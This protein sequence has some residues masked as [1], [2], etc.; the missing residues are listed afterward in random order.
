MFDELEV[1][2]RRWP[3]HVELHELNKLQTCMY[4]PTCTHSSHV[5]LEGM[6]GLAFCCSLPHFGFVGC[7]SFVAWSCI[8]SLN[9]NF[10]WS[11]C[12]IW[13][14]VWSPEPWH[15][16]W[17]RSARLQNRIQTPPIQT[18][19]ICKDSQPHSLNKSYSITNWPGHHQSA[20]PPRLQRRIR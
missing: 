20:P 11:M 1:C 14:Y 8:V 6:A 7:I 18:R 16:P 13:V 10:T 12:K 3:C 9:H 2:T 4:I 19:C 17:R 5:K 15:Q